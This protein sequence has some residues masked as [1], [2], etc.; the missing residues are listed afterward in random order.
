MS[1]IFSR[2]VINTEMLQTTHEK[3]NS[4]Q[5]SLVIHTRKYNVKRRCPKYLSW[6]L[7]CDILRCAF[8]LIYEWIYQTAAFAVI[9]SLPPT[10]F[11]FF[12]P[13]PFPSSIISALYNIYFLHFLFFI[14]PGLS[15]PLC[16]PFLFLLLLLLV[17]MRIWL[18]SSNQCPFRSTST[19]QKP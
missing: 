16:F 13:R 19:T 4:K 18:S 3:E 17:L 11:F 7:L 8:Y 12:F 14:L 10:F 9:E 6:F 1:T 15:F 2:R 5:T